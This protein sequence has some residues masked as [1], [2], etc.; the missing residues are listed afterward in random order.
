MY[1]KVKDYHEVLCKANA[2][3]KYHIQVTFN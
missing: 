2:N 1:G 3:D